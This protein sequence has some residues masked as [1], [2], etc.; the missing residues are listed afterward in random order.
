VT[1]DDRDL[2]ETKELDGSS[3]TVLFECNHRNNEFCR[4]VRLRQTGP[5]SAGSRHL[6][7]GRIEFFGELRE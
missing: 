3:A 2:N 7:L 1:I 6:V 5:N 4:F